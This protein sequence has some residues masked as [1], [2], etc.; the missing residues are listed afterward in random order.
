[1]FEVIKFRESAKWPKFVISAAFDFHGL[2]LTCSKI[3]YIHWYIAS[4]LEISF[5]D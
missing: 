3:C 1:M 5:R 2:Y 4:Y